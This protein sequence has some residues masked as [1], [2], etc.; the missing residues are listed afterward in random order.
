MLI[1]ASVILFD[2]DSHTYL[3]INSMVA[4]FA[5]VVNA[6][7]FLFHPNGKKWLRYF[8][9][10]WLLWFSVIEFMAY[11]YWLD[12]ATH[13]ATYIRPYLPLLYLTSVWDVMVDWEKPLAKDPRN[14]ARL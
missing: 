11:M 3:L 1:F 2:V 4:F 7:Y 9:A 12:P 8:S 14:E 13:G 5:F 6:S 10:G